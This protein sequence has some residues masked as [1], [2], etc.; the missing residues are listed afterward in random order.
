MFKLIKK[1]R[2]I[3]FLFIVFSFVINPCLVFAKGF[4]G[5]FSSNE[6]NTS[7]NIEKT[8]PVAIALKYE[9]NILLNKD[10]DFEVYIDNKEYDKITQ[11]QGKLYFI[12]LTEGKHE[13]KLKLSSFKKASI[14]FDVVVEKDNLD[15]Y[16][17]FY[18]LCSYKKSKVKVIR[19]G[20]WYSKDG[21]SYTN[22][23]YLDDFQNK[24]KEYYGLDVF[25]QKIKEYYGLDLNLDTEYDEEVNLES[26][27]FQDT[28]LDEYVL[29]DSSS[30]KL[31]LESLKNLNSSQLRIARNEIY[32]RH[33]YIFGDDELNI[34]FSNKSW[35]VPI[36]N[37]VNLNEIELYNIGIIKQAESELE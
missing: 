2:D 25:Q 27:V 5:L 35:Y 11:N 20:T 8:F 29:P 15:F 12:F 16:N 18:F 26:E 6:D 37:D 7:E 14:D 36:G 19:D 31:T 32:A 30:K 4:W 33:G 34:Y 17:D 28:R 24:A 22:I 3:L 10:K 23:N 9:G 21:V 13:L 1:F